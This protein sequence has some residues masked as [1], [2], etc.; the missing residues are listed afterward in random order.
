MNIEATELDFLGYYRNLIMITN[1]INTPFM[2]KC[3]VT[4]TKKMWLKYRRK[5]NF[6]LMLL[7]QI[8]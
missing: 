8:G 7:F 4:E 3:G 5:R 2:S 1:I 6:P